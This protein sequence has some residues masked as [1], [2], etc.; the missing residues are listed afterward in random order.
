MLYLFWP[1]L[2]LLGATLQP[3]A[4]INAL[5]ADKEELPHLIQTT[6]LEEDYKA[7]VS[8]ELAMTP[9]AKEDDL[10]QAYANVLCSCVRI[11]V[12]GHYGSGSIYKMLEKEMIIVT[13]RHVLQYWNEDSYVTFFDGRVSGGSLLGISKEED[14]GFISVPT[15]RFSYEELLSYRNVRMRRSVEGDNKKEEIP[16]NGSRL[17]LVDLA[18]EWNT[19]VMK[20]GEI[21]SPLIYLE[22]FHTEMLYAK[23]DAVP[24]M[25]GCGVFDGYGNYLGMLT[26]GTMQG[27]IAAV[28]AETINRKYTNADTLRES[29]Y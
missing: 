1:L 13:N 17:F 23:G 4:G 20:E 22:D 12:E 16:V 2:A 19:P 8:L 6:T 3:M 18:S 28:P 10:Q 25:S 9:L 27:E 11:Q 24:G 21:I 15:D 14:L 29:S 7:A 5:A 26:G